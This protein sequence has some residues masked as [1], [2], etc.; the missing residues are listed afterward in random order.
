M[1]LRRRLDTAERGRE[2]LDRKL[3]ILIPKRQRL[4]TR[5]AR[6]REEWIATHAEAQTWLLRASLLGGQDAIRVATPSE[7]V[8]V[9]VLWTSSM[10][11]TYPEDITLANSGPNQPV[12]AGNAAVDPAATAFQ[13]ALLAGAR[14]AAVDEAVRRL[15][16][17]IAVTHR[18]MRA[19]D[20]RWLPWLQ[21]SLATLEL[22][23]EQAE[24]EDAMRLRRTTYPST[25]GT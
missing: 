1:W 14:A 23:L 6:R 10:G 16:A 13:A 19:L 2:Q 25:G 4:Q 8:D 7:L 18:R 22:S 17:E 11:L 5:A 21:N 24:Q 9:T 12:L 3:R 20:K 15:D